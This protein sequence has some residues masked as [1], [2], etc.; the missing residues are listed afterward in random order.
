MLRKKDS[1]VQGLKISTYWTLVFYQQYGNL[2][3]LPPPLRKG[4]YNKGQGQS[5]GQSQGQEE[6]KEKER[7]REE[8][9]R[10]RG[11]ERER[12]QASEC[13]SEM[14]PVIID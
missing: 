3:L 9:P 6:V 5:Q 10:E 12:P 11:R 1:V 2:G 14:C 4:R 8:K 7:S 13:H